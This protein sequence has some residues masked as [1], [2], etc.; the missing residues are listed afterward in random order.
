VRFE[1]VTDTLPGIQALTR[2]L[3]SSSLSSLIVAL[4][5]QLGLELEDTLGPVET[6]VIERAERPTEN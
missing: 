2:P 6:L 4:R 1:T 5:D 3:N